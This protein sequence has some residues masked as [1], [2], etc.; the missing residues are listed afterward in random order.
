MKPKTIFLCL[1]VMGCV[2][3]IGHA[4]TLQEAIEESLI[5]PFATLEALEAQA[6]F[7]TASSSDYKVARKKTEAAQNE[8]FAAE[9]EWEAATYEVRQVDRGASI[10]WW[11]LTPEKIKE[12]VAKGKKEKLAAAEK[13]QK[14]AWEKL[15]AA[16]KKHNA[17]R[18]N[19][20]A[21]REKWEAVKKAAYSSAITDAKAKARQGKKR[22]RHCRVTLKPVDDHLEIV[23]DC[24]MRTNYGSHRGC[25]HYR[26]RPIPT[27]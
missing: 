17:A 2:P 1:V 19:E 20:T 5:V 12:E 3:S 21:V 18:E 26:N 24:Q 16:E 27:G 10:L 7:E 15:A 4:D 23:R 22:A 9:D 14:A 11:L 6:D 25:V 13:K 8:R